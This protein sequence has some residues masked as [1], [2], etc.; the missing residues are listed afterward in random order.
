[1]SELGDCI[2]CPAQSK[3]IWRVS[4]V[5]MLSCS[6]AIYRGHY[7]LAI[8]PGGVF[9]T[10]INYWRL[11]TYGWR[12]NLDI[13][14]VYGALI[15]QNIRA[16][17]MTTAAPYYHLIG[18][19]SLLY[20]INIYLYKK[21][22]YWWSTYVHCMLHIIA[23]IGNMVLYSGERGDGCGDGGDYGGGYGSG[24]G[25][26]RPPSRSAA[27]FCPFSYPCFF[28]GHIVSPIRCYGVS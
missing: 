1:M 6:Y 13:G 2:L 19:A 25:V 21:K 14:C 18:I 4:F 3:C 15:Y 24:Y 20:P 8:V 28:R 12:R 11:P 23:N 27:A 7:D 17:K 26:C 9:M 16:Y 10:S 22:C 5:S